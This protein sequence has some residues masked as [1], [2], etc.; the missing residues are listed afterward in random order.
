MKNIIKKFKAWLT[1]PFGEKKRAEKVAHVQKTLKS[2]TDDELIALGTVLEELDWIQS[3]CWYVEVANR[4]LDPKIKEKMAK[5]S[6][7]PG[8]ILG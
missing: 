2:F 7:H 1:D 4:W 3:H 8:R 6:W 5:K